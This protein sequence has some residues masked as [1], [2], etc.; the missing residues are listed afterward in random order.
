MKSSSSK[1][2]QGTGK[3]T[4]KEPTVPRFP[5]VWLSLFVLSVVVFWVMPWQLGTPKVVVK[6]LPPAETTNA[7]LK[8]RQQ[9]GPAEIVPSATPPPGEVT[10]TD[11]ANPPPA[12]RERGVEIESQRVWEGSPR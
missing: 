4:G 6:G 12:P 1:T 7:V 11:P 5:W 3:G 2:T 8:E 9:G 10:P